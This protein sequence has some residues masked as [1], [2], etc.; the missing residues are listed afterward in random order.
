MGFFTQHYHS[1][2]QYSL[3]STHCGFFN[4]ETHLQLSFLCYGLVTTGKPHFIGQL[5]HPSIMKNIQLCAVI[6]Q[7]LANA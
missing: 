7:K 1:R 3:M 6:A 4:V 2:L 5:F